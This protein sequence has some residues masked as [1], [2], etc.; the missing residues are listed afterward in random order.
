[1]FANEPPITEVTETV[2]VAAGWVA[3]GAFFNRKSKLHTPAASDG[4][5][6]PRTTGVE[7][8]LFQVKVTA[9][10]AEQ[11]CAVPRMRH[12]APPRLNEAESTPR[13]SGS[14]VTVTLSV[15]GRRPAAFLTVSAN[16]SVCCVG[17][18]GAMN[19]GLATSVRD[20]VTAGPA[21][22]TQV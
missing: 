12:S 5:S 21:V 11:Y 14:V 6:V 17:L 7:P 9:L 4:V 3:A 19:V 22:W 18:A 15:D 10:L 2:P 8:G 20:S 13:S 1:M 16:V